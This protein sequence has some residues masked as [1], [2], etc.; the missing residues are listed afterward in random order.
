[1]KMAMDGNEP[2]R[3]IS[4]KRYILLTFFIIFF[5]FAFQEHRGITRSDLPKDAKREV[6][7]RSRVQFALDRATPLQSRGNPEGRII[8]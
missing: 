6:P 8:P 4:I 7:F 1:M 5:N 3:R 2:D